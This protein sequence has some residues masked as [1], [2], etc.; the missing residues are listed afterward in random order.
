MD[1]SAK[2]GQVLIAD[3]HSGMLAAVRGLL[4]GLFEVLVMVADEASLLAVIPRLNPDLVVV[5]LSLPVKGRRH[6]VQ[7]LGE[8]F[9]TLK[10]IVLGVHSEPEAARAALSS[11][12]A[13]YVL[14]RTA[15][16][17]LAE[18][19]LS[20]RSGRTYISASVI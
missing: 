18:A 5:D 9:P 15:G 17:D 8:R 19:V 3:V 14:K 7:Q 20:V 4:E 1:A 2:C 12:A 6:I 11:G 16:T 10:V 13:G